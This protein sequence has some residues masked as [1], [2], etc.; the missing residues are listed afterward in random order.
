VSYDVTL[1]EQD[2]KGD[3]YEVWSGNYTS[4]MSYAWYEVGILINFWG[5]GDYLARDVSESVRAGIEK[6]ENNLDHFRQGEPENGW[7]SV[8]GML[9]RFLVPMFDAMERWPEARIWVSR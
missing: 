5:D 7:G 3:E 1:L 9:E 8:A 6:I 4:N 2:A